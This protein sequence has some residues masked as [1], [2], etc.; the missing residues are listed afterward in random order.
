MLFPMFLG[1]NLTSMYMCI[2]S[3]LVLNI[4]VLLVLSSIIA[5]LMYHLMHVVA[6]WNSL[7][8]CLFYNF[9]LKL[10]SVMTVILFIR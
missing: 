4:L 7:H 3:S 9:S 1:P 6:S 8:I 5:G 10:A 2:I